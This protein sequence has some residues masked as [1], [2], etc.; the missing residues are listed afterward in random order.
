M[1]TVPAASAAFTMSS[2]V[3]FASSVTVGTGAVVSMV[4]ASAAEAGPVLPAASVAV[5]LML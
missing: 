3:M 5:A 1:V 4:I 2:A